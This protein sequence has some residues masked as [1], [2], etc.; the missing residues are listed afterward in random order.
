MENSNVKPINRRR[1][2]RFLLSPRMQLKYGA[3]YSAIA[4]AVLLI[5]GGMAVFF[6]LEL[7]RFSQKTAPGQTLVEYLT[8][9]LKMH[10]WMF[11][12]G[13]LVSAALFMSLAIVL[14]ERIVG[15][16]RAL[17]RHIDALKAGKYDVKTSLR[18]N[19]ELKPLMIALNELSDTLKAKHG[20]EESF[21]KTGTES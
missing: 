4:G 5:W 8:A 11:A 19:D 7:V 18:K 21:A 9:L 15:P 10:E 20:V 17:A 13:F 1:F 6:M 3:Y 16:T 2:Y 14:T 12:T